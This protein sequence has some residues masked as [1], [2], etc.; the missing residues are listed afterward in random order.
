MERPGLPR[1]SLNYL[2]KKASERMPFFVAGILI[3]LSIVIVS[4][5][6]L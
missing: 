3:W 2:I 4:K 1:R 6:K 5:M